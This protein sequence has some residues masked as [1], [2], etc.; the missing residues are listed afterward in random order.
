MTQPTAIHPYVLTH[1]KDDDGTD[2]LFRF[3]LT[4]G[5]K[6]SEKVGDPSG[7]ETIESRLGQAIGTLDGIDGLGVGGGR[8]TIEVT[9]AR[10]FDPNE[11]ITELKQRLDSDVLSEI[12]TPRLVTP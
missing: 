11:V 4:L 8:Y 7:E 3:M 10:T 1:P 9:I 2:I 6:L 12:I 5:K